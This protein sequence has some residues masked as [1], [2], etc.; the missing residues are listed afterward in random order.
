MEPYLGGGYGFEL[1]GFLERGELP[2]GPIESVP[3]EMRGRTVLN[4]Y[5]RYPSSMEY[6]YRSVY[7]VH[8]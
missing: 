2:D 6:S 5:R 7:V 1:E 8:L 4:V 3:E